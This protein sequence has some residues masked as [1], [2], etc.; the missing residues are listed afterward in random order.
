MAQTRYS[1]L[2]NRARNLATYFHVEHNFRVEQQIAGNLICTRYD[3]QGY[4]KDQV[5]VKHAVHDFRDEDTA[6]E[7]ITLRAL[8]GCEHIV[9]LLSIVDSEDNAD[10]TRPMRRGRTHPRPPL[11]WNLRILR[12]EYPMLLRFP[13]FVIEHLARGTVED[14]I[15]GRQEWRISEPLLWCFFLCLIRGCLGMAYPPHELT[16]TD[17]LPTWREQPPLN[18]GQ[19]YPA[20]YRMPSRWVHGD[21]HIGNVMFGSLGD[22]AQPSCHPGMIDFGFAEEFGSSALWSVAKN[23]R[24]VGGIMEQLALM[25]ETEIAGDEDLPRYAI[26]LSPNPAHNFETF[27]TPEFRDLNRLSL[28]FRKLV[29]W[30][31]AVEWEQRPDLA[32]VFGIC[33]TSVRNIQ[34]SQ[35]LAAECNVLFDY[36][37]D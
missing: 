17:L 23:I 16:E 13:F 20:A 25:Q 18:M 36:A 7:L 2:P 32:L 4:I 34:N 5:V 28:D 33:E 14:L 3:V 11:P 22:R 9:R 26:S 27:A 30:C 12:G 21:L 1:D 19:Q 29:S 15:K 6:K 8:W 24:D 31:L 37:R 10:L 35:V